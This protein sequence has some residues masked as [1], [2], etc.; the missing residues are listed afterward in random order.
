MPDLPPREATNAPAPTGRAQ[1]ERSAVTHSKILRAA[2]EIIDEN[3]FAAATLSMILE[4]AEVTKGSLYYH[5]RSKE[6]IAEE[7]L[8]IQVPMSRVK[9]Q[10]SK[11]QETID[12][13]FIYAHLLQ[14]EP[15]ARA[16][17]RLS[18]DGGA[19]PELDVYGPTRDW[20][21]LATHLM[22]EAGAAGHL[23]PHWTPESAASIIQSTF[24][25][26]QLT[27]MQIT[28][29]KRSDLPQRITNMWKSL[30]P[31]LAAPGLLLGLDFEEDRWHR[32]PWEKDEPHAS[33]AMHRP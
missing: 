9:P 13:S 17:I 19:P 7:L 10:S 11:F 31:G 25:G 8:A 20:I 15:V 33:S 28:G 30:L 16:A 32:I 24:V 3:G 5:F 2:A 29:P 6:Q 21:A 1:Q 18:I 22:T 27:S 4:R 23:L 12:I 14:E 26:A